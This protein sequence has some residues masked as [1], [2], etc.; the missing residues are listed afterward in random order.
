MSFLQ[1][2]R[3]FKR[4]AVAGETSDPRLSLSDPQVL[5][6]RARGLWIVPAEG[7]A[8]GAPG[9]EPPASTVLDEQEQLLSAMFASSS[10]GVGI[11][12]SELRFEK[13]N[14]ALAAMNGLS[15]EA[16]RGQN[17]LDILGESADQI[18]PI[19]REVIS[20]GKPA[21]NQER[22]F[23]ITTRAD[24]GHWICDFFPLKNVDGKVVKVAVIVV[25]VTAQ[26]PST[27]SS[28]PELARNEAR[29]NE[30]VG[31]SVALG[32][33]LHK[34]KAVAPSDATVLILGEP[35][36]GKELIARAIHR[37]SPR[38]EKNFATINCAAIPAGLLESELFGYEKGAFTGANQQKLGRLELANYGTLFLDEIGEMPLETQDK[39]LRVLESCEF[40]R[41]G[42]TRTLQ[43]DIRIIAATDQDLSLRVAERAFRSKL[44]YR[45][46]VFA[47][48][49][50]PL[51]NR[52]E[53]IPGL[54]HY[55][56]RKHAQR[57]QKKIDAIDEGMIDALIKYDWPGNIRELENFMERAVILSA[58]P[59]LRQHS[60]V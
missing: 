25:E 48:T 43:T 54:A 5:L 57:L 47:I 16:L 34:A 44:Y 36:T 60:E 39:L 53:D 24:A 17:V 40:E 13:F 9:P 31:E 50:P 59:L 29:L 32:D 18:E 7:S 58:G 1:G 35:G 51:R 14:D 52:K 6:D 21:L 38:S 26:R 49:L 41:L 2:P 23:K 8:A 45:L 46:N 33:A 19:F 27:P 28:K 4:T 30:I 3:N 12:D 42:G 10:I 15:S 37:I 11:F 55:F 20:S 56:A 22:S